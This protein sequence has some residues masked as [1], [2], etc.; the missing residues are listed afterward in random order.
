MLLAGHAG[1]VGPGRQNRA[2]RHF[3]A[4]RLIFLLVLFFAGG[5]PMLSAVSM[6]HFSKTA[7][8]LR[9]S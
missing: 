3:C 5:F 9:K 1:N 7:N 4:I 8:S 2:D 6:C